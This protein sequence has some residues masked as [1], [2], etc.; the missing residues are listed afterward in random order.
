[1][2]ILMLILPHRCFKIVLF[3]LFYENNFKK[4]GKLIL[5]PKD[6]TFITC[7]KN[8]TYLTWI[9]WFVSAIKKLEPT[10]W[11]YVL[12]ETRFKL[13]H[14]TERISNF[15]R[16]LIFWNA[17]VSSYQKNPKRTECSHTSDFQACYISFESN[18]K[19]VT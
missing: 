18:F 10:D 16:K 12:K 6:A 1:M 15:M 17:P 14:N 11:N 9:T 19:V 2:L 4:I 7:T 8:A 3:V 13:C 5:C